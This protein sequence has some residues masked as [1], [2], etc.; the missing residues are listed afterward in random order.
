[1]E[2]DFLKIP[3]KPSYRQKPNSRPV[4]MIEREKLDWI[5]YE[6]WFRGRGIFLEKATV[7]IDGLFKPLEV[8]DQQPTN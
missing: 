7:I 5:C 2:K 1:M 4:C 6:K 8:S 3:Q